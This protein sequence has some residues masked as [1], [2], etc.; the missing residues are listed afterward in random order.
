MNIILAQTKDASVIH[1]VMLQAFKEYEH[2]T[3]PSSALSETIESIEQA[4]ENG[5]QA[6]IGYIDEQPVAMVRFTLSAQGIYFF[7]LSVIPE[8]QGQGLAKALI[9]EL[10]QYA[11]TNG[12]STSGCKVRMSVPRN[13]ELY[14]SLGYIVTKESKEENR[15]GFS[16]SVAT[17]E[18][19]LTN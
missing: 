5:E 16:L 2:A 7:R 4:M 9:E 19:Q 6:F 18:K 3:P 1:N 12:K 11:F 8:K 13:I 10:E 17:M 15:N 14:R